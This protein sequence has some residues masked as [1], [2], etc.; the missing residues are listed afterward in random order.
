MKNIP[1]KIKEA[2][3]WVLVFTILNV[4]FRTIVN[5]IL[6]FLDTEYYLY[7]FD[8]RIL[9]TSF[10]QSLSFLMITLLTIKWINRKYYYFV[11]PI[12]L[13]LLLNLVFFF[14][15]QLENNTIIFLTHSITSSYDCYIYSSNIVS[16]ILFFIKPLDDYSLFD[17]WTF[18]V[19]NIIYFYILFALSSFIYFLGLTCLCNYIINII[20]KKRQDIIFFLNFEL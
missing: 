6:F 3:K 10:F 14:N 13:F 9:A 1:A 18:I 7:Y 20:K 11:F 12:T 16:D 4:L 8:A 19:Y 5:L 15:L 17:G 2:I